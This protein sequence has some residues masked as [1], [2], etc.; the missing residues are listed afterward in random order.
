MKFLALAIAALLLQGAEAPKQEG[1]LIAWKP[2]AGSVHKYKQ[3]MRSTSHNIADINGK[4]AD[5]T[6]EETLILTVR[7]I[8]DDGTVEIEAQD[9]DRKSKLGD[10]DL[11]TAGGNFP[12]VVST[13]VKNANGAIVSRISGPIN[14]TAEGLDRFI[15]P[16]TPMAPG[17]A[18]S[19]RIKGD[20]EKGT[21]D[22]EN[23]WTFRGKDKVLDVECHKIETL[24]KEGSGDTPIEA[25][26][27]TWL[28]QDDG[29]IVK[30]TMNVKNFNH[31]PVDLEMTME[32]IK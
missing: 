7:K 17:Q 18:W 27:I 16:R 15:Y 29:E 19:F 11:L 8:N 25:T 3:T 24:Y 4:A 12:A 2:K 9:T 13:V 22:S 1:T 10:K 30:R 5:L 20:A 32:L 28:S 21:V 26:G 6:V 23:T 14:V 31:Q